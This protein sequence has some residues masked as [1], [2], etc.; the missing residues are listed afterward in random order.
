MG[1]AAVEIL[2]ALGAIRPAEAEA[3][4]AHRRPPVHDAAGHVVGRL[5]AA[6]TVGAARDVPA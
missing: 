1:P 3:L 4:V 2:L 5:E 6:V